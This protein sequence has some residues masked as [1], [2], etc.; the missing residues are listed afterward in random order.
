MKSKIYII[1][2]AVIILL[3]IVFGIYHRST[4]IEKSEQVPQQK[5][6]TDI[7]NVQSEI[8][9]PKTQSEK[10]KTEPS[11]ES[12]ISDKSGQQI[13]KPVEVTEKTEVKPLEVNAALNESQQQINTPGNQKISEVPSENLRNAP[14]SGV[15]QSQNQTDKP[16]VAA[17]PQA[18]KPQ[19][20]PLAKKL[21]EAESYVA[22]GNWQAAERLLLEIRVTEPNYPGLDALNSR[23]QNMK[24]GTK[25]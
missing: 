8:N 11:P 19:N 5:T 22:A 17:Q 2:A 4:G 21:Q 24:T 10:A 1:G 25:K 6:N 3:W 16:K 9:I 23:V 15:D 13:E 18:V 14:P 12:N 20:D 7:N